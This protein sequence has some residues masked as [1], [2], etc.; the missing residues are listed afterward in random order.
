M[1]ARMPITSKKRKHHVRAEFPSATSSFPFN[2]AVVLVTCNDCEALSV[3][4]EPFS[5]S[6]TIWLMFACQVTILPT[7]AA[8]SPGSLELSRRRA[9]DYSS[10]PVMSHFQSRPILS[11]DH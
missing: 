9:R 3:G 10:F 8:I 5:I 4:F 2:T 6:L 7:L 11:Q 1:L